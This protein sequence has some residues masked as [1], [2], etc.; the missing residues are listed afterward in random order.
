MWNNNFAMQRPRGTWT[1]FDDE[2]LVAE[3][4]SIPQPDRGLLF[5]A[6]QRFAK[7][8]DAGFTLKDYGDDLLML[9]KQGRSG[10]SLFFTYDEKDKTKL[11]LLL[12]YKKESGDAPDNLINTARER[13]G[14]YIERRK[15][16]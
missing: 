2:I 14:R 4:R 16:K 3:M 10:R 11:V 12:A 5:F 13:R 8:D 7:G 15:E 1:N 9:K 6:M